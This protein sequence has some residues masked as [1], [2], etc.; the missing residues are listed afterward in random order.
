MTA[1]MVEDV[2]YKDLIHSEA[3]GIVLVEATGRSSPLAL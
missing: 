3:Y 2:L 1:D